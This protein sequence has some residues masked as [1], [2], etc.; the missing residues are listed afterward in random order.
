MT[1]DP[2]LHP[3]KVVS[4]APRPRGL[5]ITPGAEPSQ[6]RWDH[7]LPSAPPAICL[8]PL[9]DDGKFGALVSIKNKWLN[10]KAYCIRR[11]LTVVAEAPSD[12]AGP[13]RGMWVA[14]VCRADATT[15][16][17]GPGARKSPS[18][19]LNRFTDLQLNSRF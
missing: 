14:K 16:P 3:S 1:Q 10:R 6:Q 8:G 18:G 11:K 2:S 7:P 19:G 9:R 17:C 4:I 15:G 13:G 5:V 12:F